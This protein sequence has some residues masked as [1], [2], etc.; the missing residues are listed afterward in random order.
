MPNLDVSLVL[1]CFNEAETFSDSIK[2]IISVLD[3]TQFSWEIIFVDDTSR[4]STKKFIQNILK[5]YPK[6]RIRAIYHQKNL[7][8]G[9]AVMDGINQAQGRIVGF[10]DIDLEVSPEYLPSFFKALENGY[11]CAI[12]WRIYDFTIAGFFRWFSSKGYTLIRKII[13]GLPYKDTEA[14]YKF[15]NRSKILA[16]IKKCHNKGW[17]WDTE[18]MAGIFKAHLKTIEIPVVFIRR[19][20]KT[21]T[22]KLIPDSFKY[23]RD[24]ISFRLNYE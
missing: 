6:K 20:D 22:V 2:K 10:I 11:D 13:L 21:S 14:G 5:K 12:A 24:L 18:I 8:R 16:V 23:L 4:D 17:F 19:Q 3:G 15:F 9:Q 7:G 1:P